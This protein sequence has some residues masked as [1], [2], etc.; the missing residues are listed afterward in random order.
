MEKIHISRNILICIYSIFK[1]EKSNLYIYKSHLIGVS[2]RNLIFEDGEKR[3]S[4][5]IC[6]G[7]NT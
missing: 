7:D 1:I 4:T 2:R 5:Y 3:D 6:A